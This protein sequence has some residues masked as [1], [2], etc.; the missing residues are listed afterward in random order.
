MN[1]RHT[2]RGLVFLVAALTPGLVL[3]AT[4]EKKPT[5]KAQQTAQK[6]LDQ[7]SREAD[8]AVREAGFARV[9]I[10][11]GQVDQAKK[12][13]EDAKANLAKA[14]LNAPTLTVSVQ[15]VE[16]SGGKTLDT[17]KV[18]QTS[19][20]LPIDASLALSEDYV[21][22]PEK[23]AKVKEANEHLKKGNH[24]KAMQV[25]KEAD[26]GVSVSRVLMPLQRT[27]DEVDGALKQVNAGK[28]YEANL[29]LK[30][31]EDGL[32]VDSVVLDAPEG[33]SSAG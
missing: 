15:A 17:Q 10:F 26:I 9:A 33:A 3:A 20:L 14:K 12:L 4:A 31:I 5:T 7:V 2:R 8:V 24:P 13:L 18:T 32:I 19:D 28:Y 22:T 25:L 1:H 11:D 30:G 21:A 23:A 6:V 16:K 27:I 29:T